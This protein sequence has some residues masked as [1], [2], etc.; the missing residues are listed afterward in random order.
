MA[1]ALRRALEAPTSDV[2]TPV[3][4]KQVRLGVD[5]IIALHRNTALQQNERASVRQTITA[6][7][8][9]STAFWSLV[10]VGAWLALH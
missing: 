1:A 2:F 8:L 9:G 5:E 3:G 4:A 10:L 6:V 7:A